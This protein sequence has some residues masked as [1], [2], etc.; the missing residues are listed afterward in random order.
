MDRRRNCDH[1]Q[2]L[3][4]AYVA[5]LSRALG[6]SFFV[7]LPRSGAPFF[8]LV[9]TAYIRLLTLMMAVLAALGVLTSVLM[10]TRE[11]VHDLGVF[12]PLR[13]NRTLSGDSQ[14]PDAEM[15]RKCTHARKVRR[16]AA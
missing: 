15:G 8:E 14:P 3:R 10:V 16:G 9:D 2:L 11:R 7:S 12:G 1:L 5:A 13:S 4:Q 6:P